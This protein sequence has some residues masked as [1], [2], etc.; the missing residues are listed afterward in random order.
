MRQVSRQGQGNREFVTRR[1]ADETIIVPVVGGVGDLDAIFTLNEVGSHIWALID[2]PTTVH[3]IVEDV[4]RTFDAPPDRAE[5]DVVEFLDKL[6]DAGLIRAARSGDR[7]ALIARRLPTKRRREQAGTHAGHTLMDT[8]SYGEFSQTFHE[9]TMREHL[10]LSGTIEVTRRCP[11]T[12]VHCYNNLPMADHEAAA[13]RARPTR[14]TAGSSTSS[15]TPAACGCCSPAARS[16]RGAISS[17]STP[18][19]R[20][21]GSSSPSS[22]TAR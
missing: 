10:P 4:G 14:S 18:T 2:A 12:C 20:R 17:T 6:A 5:R 9:R 22:P 7:Y 8:V 15:P 1:I 16:S 19:R 13:H 21:R 11:L 3:A